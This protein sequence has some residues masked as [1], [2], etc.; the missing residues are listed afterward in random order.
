TRLD[1]VLGAGQAGH[2]LVGDEEGDLVAALAEL[3]EE[4]ERLLAGPGTED[5]VA[6]PE[7][8]PQV[9]SD[10]REDRRLV[11]DRDDGRP[12]LPLGRGVLG[13]SL[14]CCDRHVL[15]SLQRSDS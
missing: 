15:R 8:A 13:A 7:A 11:V 12:A 4:V 3:L 9:A 1:E 2:L 10:G 5:A 14:R 6:L